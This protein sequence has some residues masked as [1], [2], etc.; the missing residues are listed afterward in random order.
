[1]GTPP[2]GG[3]SGSVSTGN[4]LGTSIT[5]GPNGQMSGQTTV[6]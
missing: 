4:G 5:V 2:G 6:P 3:Q 1:M